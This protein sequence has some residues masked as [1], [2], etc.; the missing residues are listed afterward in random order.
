[1]RKR[2]GI[3][4]ELASKVDQRVFRW[5]TFVEVRLNDL[6]TSTQPRLGWI[7]G[8]KEAVCSRWMNVQVT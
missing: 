4:R 8:V 2:T 6:D 3:E 5:F 7:D 1:M